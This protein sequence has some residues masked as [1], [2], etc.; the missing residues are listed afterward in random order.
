MKSI[1]KSMK[2]LTIFL[3][4]MAIV[5][6]ISPVK[7]QAAKLESWL[8][9]YDVSKA[10]KKVMIPIGL[11]EKVGYF[12]LRSKSKITSIKSSDTNVVYFDKASPYLVTVVGKKDGKANVSIKVKNKSYKIQ[13]S[14]YKYKNPITS[15]TIG[16]KKISG[17]KFNEKDEHFLKY[18][19]F[20]NK[21][22]KFKINLKKD[23]FVDGISLYNSSDGNGVEIKNG[24]KFK[25]KNDKK[26]AVMFCY[27]EN[28]KTGQRGYLTIWFN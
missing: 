16:D 11:N 27:L 28:K 8:L 22:I 19:S 10:P 2:K 5:S 14:V 18:K 3:L 1:L 25:L 9:E 20:K 6:S 24:S 26:F 7:T 21:N 15:V 23:W 17:S 12:N 4:I 13:V